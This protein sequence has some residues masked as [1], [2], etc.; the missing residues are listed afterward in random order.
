M[1]D[2]EP[3]GTR[4]R[5]PITSGEAPPRAP[6]GRSVTGGLDWVEVVSAIVLALATIA[7]AWS[8]YQATR[9]SGVQS[10]AFSEANAARTL[11]TQAYTR[12]GQL[13]EIDVASFIAWA[14]AVANGD[15]ELR[16]FLFNRF[17]PE[18]K[19][20]VDAW[21]ATDPL[22]D[23]NA[24]PTPF[25]ME[26]YVVEERLEGDRLL[27]EADAR[28]QE[29]RDANQTGDNYVLTTVLFA[30]VL[31]FAG[32]ATKF[33]GRVVKGVLVAFALLAFAGG[34]IIIATFPVH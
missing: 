25:A 10:I 29:A 12:A 28:G 27:A 20:A 31:F 19:T 24:P 2:D 18:F 23:P 21:R 4:T 14:E 34:A 15:D 17:R 9:W 22:N 26:E 5:P 8:A 3:D 6:R 16:D 30:S 13:T 1:H 32:I 7:S 11:G 33:T